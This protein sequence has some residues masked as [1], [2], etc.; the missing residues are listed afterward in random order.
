MRWVPPN[1][2]MTRALTRAGRTWPLRGVDEVA[3]QGQLAAAAEGEAVEPPPPRPCGA[4]DR[5]GQRAAELG[6]GLGLQR[7]E[8]EHLADV[9]PAANACGAGE[10][11]TRM[12]SD[13]SISR[14]PW[15]ARRGPGGQRVELGLAADR[16][17]GERP[18]ELDADQ[19]VLVR[20]MGPPSGAGANDGALVVVLVEAAAGLLAEPAGGDVLAEQRAR[21]VLVVAELAW[22]T[23]AIASTVSR[24]IRS[25]SSSEPIGWLRRAGSRCRCR[26]LPR[27]R[28][29]RSRPR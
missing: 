15:S 13:I 14:P 10:A 12:S 11:T 2:G 5:G 9:A 8:L 23:S 26:R 18:L 28:R 27:P 16:H 24:P 7:A 20:N 25:A 1:P 6:E 19:V 22:R 4:L 3:R 21:P 17:D 29:G